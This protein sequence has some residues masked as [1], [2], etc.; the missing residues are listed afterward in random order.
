MKTHYQKFFKGVLILL[1]IWG[2][3]GSINAQ[4]SEKLPAVT[5]IGTALSVDYSNNN[6]P[7][8]TV[9]TK[10]N[11]FDGNLS[12]YFASYDRSGTWVGLDL[13]EKHIITKIAYA[14]RN[15]FDG[16]SQ[17]LVLGVFEGASNPD[18][19]DAVPLLMITEAPQPN[20]LTE[21]NINCS[22]GFRYVRYVGPNDVRCNIAEIEFYG[23]P[24]AGDNSYFPQLTN[25]PVITIHTVNAQDI[26]SKEVYVPGFVSFIY[27]DGKSIYS[28]NL[29][30]R[31]RGNASWD[32]PKKPYRMKLNSKVNLMGFPAR[33][34]NWTLINNYGDK[35]LM[36]NLLAFDLSRRLDMAYTS[37]GIPVDVVLNGEYKGT[38]QLCDQIEVAP[39]RV[40]VQTMNAGDIALPNL[41]GGYFLEVD[42]Y[43]YSE[44]S[45]FESAGR[46]TPV[47]I[48]YPK[49]DEIVT[50]QYNYIRDHY[51]KMESAV[52]AANY[53]DPVNGYR[54]Y[55]DMESFIRHFL[56]GEIS[57]NTD[58]YWSV[59]MY[60]NRNDDIFKFG[61][62]WDFDLAYEN[63]SRTYPINNHS[64]WVYEYGSSANGFRDVV[65][66]LFSD[67][68]FVSRLKE[69][70]S[71]YRDRGILTKEALLQVVDNYAAEI[72]QS[73]QLNFMR[74]NILNTIV[75]M[76]PRTYGS[77]E[78]EVNNVKNYI[79]NRIDW[80]DRK[81]NYSP[82]NISEIAIADIV[83]YA[84]ANAICIH[85]V[86]EPVNI[87]I[88]DLTGKILL[89]KSITDNISIPASKGMY[90]ITVFDTKG[91]EKTVKCLIV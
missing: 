45:W 23:Y 22:K 35:T 43:A 50:P 88:A 36:R 61:P 10:S 38:Y 24:G 33:E 15:D 78:G 56:V 57:G 89:S 34:K 18:F 12:T 46:R 60:K 91:N 49:D 75:H 20:M 81:L 7:S 80:M 44:I 71:D 32:F 48:K 26:T 8:T 6:S 90:I 55:M 58:T 85:H 40:E 79:S 25:L 47:T 66:R 70:Y 74:W 82:T 51:N 37:V 52:F 67:E 3:A 28:D 5:I 13:G 39:G 54:K 63:D 73:Q 68:D 62:V 17:R 77:Y 42:A 14:P 72:N 30:I 53:K 86:V 41:S 16:G 64:Q 9:N 1:S 4:T 65:N 21:Q 2:Y 59:Y 87:T 19:S 84:Q 69:I 27:N 29:D 76:N 31:G 11:V 83:I